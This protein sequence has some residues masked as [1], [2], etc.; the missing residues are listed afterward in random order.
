MIKTYTYKLKPNKTLEGNFNQW[1]GTCRFVY[2]C[3]K[4]LKEQAYQKG[5]KLS[6]FDI[7]KQLSEAKKYFPWLCKVHS[8][9]LQGVIDRMDNSFVKFFKGAGYPRW[10][11]KIN[12]TYKNIL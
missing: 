3:S 12:Y 9:T 7:Q 8:Q 2:N 5:I 10:A 4:D 1:L 11:S 6:K